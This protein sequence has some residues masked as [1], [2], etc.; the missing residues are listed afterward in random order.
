[1]MR[2]S[3]RGSWFCTGRPDQDGPEVEAV[4]AQGFIGEGDRSVWREAAPSI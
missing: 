3:L 2:R 1:M 4:L